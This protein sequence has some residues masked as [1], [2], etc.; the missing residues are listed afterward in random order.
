MYK[1]N[2][3]D[4]IR[5]ADADDVCMFCL[6]KGIENLEHK[7]IETVNDLKYNM[8]GK[9]NNQKIF[10]IRKHGQD[11]C[12][13]FDCFHELNQEILDIENKD[14]PLQAHSE[15]VEENVQASNE[16]EGTTAETTVEVEEKEEDDKKDKKTKSSSN[17]N[18]SKK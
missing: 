15:V 17:K 14:K 5:T 11:V 4:N 7:N 8:K 6:K 13:C 1:I 10:Y 18:K 16:D 2:K 9:L 12:I 3:H